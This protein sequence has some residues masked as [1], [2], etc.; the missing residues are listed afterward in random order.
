MTLQLSDIKQHINVAAARLGGEPEIMRCL[1]LHF[2]DICSDGDKAIHNVLNAIK[3]AHTL[4]TV[5]DL[6]YGY[7]IVWALEDWV[8]K[9]CCTPDPWHI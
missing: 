4:C 6:E 7:Y 8:R 5:Q 3:N 1:E 9:G 2:A